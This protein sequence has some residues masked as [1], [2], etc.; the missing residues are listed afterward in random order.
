MC[1]VSLACL[2]CIRNCQ[3][4]GKCICPSHSPAEITGNDPLGKV[5]RRM[6]KYIFLNVV[7][8][9]E[10]IHMTQGC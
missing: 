5:S 9:V 3:R 1:V 7:G 6:R 8:T 2:C 4:F 10:A